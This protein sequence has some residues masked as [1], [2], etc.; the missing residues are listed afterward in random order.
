M[1]WKQVPTANKETTNQIVLVQYHY[2]KRIIISGKP[3]I[4]L[5]IEVKE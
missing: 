1:E 4:D 5:G 2:G 3:P